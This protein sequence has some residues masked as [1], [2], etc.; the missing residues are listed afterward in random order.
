MTGLDG[1]SHEQSLDS[2]DVT[3]STGHF[4]LLS[5]L[6]PFLLGLAV[7]RSGQSFREGGRVLLFV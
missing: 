3:T 7:V 5:V 6:P 2:T 4:A 1:S